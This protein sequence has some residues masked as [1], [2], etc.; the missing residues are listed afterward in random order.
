MDFAMLLGASLSA[1][2][3]PWMLRAPKYLSSRLMRWLNDRPLARPRRIFSRLLRTRLRL[4]AP[5]LR[6]PSFRAAWRNRQ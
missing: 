6:L 5:S 2:A 4:R 1:F 3:K